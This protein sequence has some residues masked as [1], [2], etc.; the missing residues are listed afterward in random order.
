MKPL[1]QEELARAQVGATLARALRARG[2]HTPALLFLTV[3]RPLSRVLAN[4]LLFAQ[5]LARPLGLGGAVGELVGI[6]EDPRSLDAL[7]A[8]LDQP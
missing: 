7:L 3:H 1:P 6:L 2:L 8:E 4:A 5:P